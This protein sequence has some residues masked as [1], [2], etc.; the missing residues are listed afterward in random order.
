MYQEGGHHHEF[1]APKEESPSSDED[2]ILLDENEIDVV[3]S[4]H[5]QPGKPPAFTP[6][7]SHEEAGVRMEI[8]PIPKDALPAD[9]VRL[10]DADVQEIPDI[11]PSDYK[12]LKEEKEEVTLSKAEL[13][14]Q[15]MQALVQLGNLEHQV[16]NSPSHKMV[17]ISTPADVRRTLFADYEALTEAVTKQKAKIF[18]LQTRLKQAAAT[19]KLDINKLSPFNE[20][21]AARQKALNKATSTKDV[22]NDWYEPE[23]AQSANG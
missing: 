19:E 3:S 15:Y 9:V 5:R 6:E 16:A 11:S 7:L 10:E 20:L 13:N 1:K 18:E 23:T 17:V 12:H 22:D 14:E 8:P 4:S 21:A 2:L